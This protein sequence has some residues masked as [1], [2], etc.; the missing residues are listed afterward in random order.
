MSRRKKCTKMDILNNIPE[1][2]IKILFKIALTLLALNSISLVLTIV[3]KT[4]T[5]IALLSTMISVVVAAGCFYVI[6]KQSSKAR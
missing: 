2:F 5:T 6:K 3:Y 4:D 1:E